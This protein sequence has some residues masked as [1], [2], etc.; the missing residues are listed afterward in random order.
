M[1]VHKINWLMI[2]MALNLLIFQVTQIKI[3]IYLDMDPLPKD[4]FK[5]FERRY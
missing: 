2:S 3:F 4:C 5:A 1:S